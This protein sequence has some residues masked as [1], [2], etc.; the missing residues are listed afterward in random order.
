MRSYRE[1]LRAL[2]LEKRAARRANNQTRTA[3]AAKLTIGKNA[4]STAAFTT[5]AEGVI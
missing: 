3:A 2:D 1:M 4:F 5:G